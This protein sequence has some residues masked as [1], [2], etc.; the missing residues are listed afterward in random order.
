M[1]F[2]IS[3]HYSYKT[4]TIHSKF[5]TQSINVL[6]YSYS[7]FTWYAPFFIISI[8]ISC[9]PISFHIYFV[10]YTYFLLHS[11]KLLLFFILCPISIFFFC[12]IHSYIPT[13]V[14]PFFWYI[15]IRKYQKI[16]ISRILMTT[17]FLKDIWRSQ[18]YFLCYVCIYLVWYDIV[19]RRNVLMRYQT[20]KMWRLKK[21]KIK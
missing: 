2:T 4:Y 1:Y 5:T 8:V 20:P 6:Y 12:T 9:H 7:T 21:K 19:Y 15:H 16:S 3:A 13:Q 11:F 17:I 14:T 18:S 10:L